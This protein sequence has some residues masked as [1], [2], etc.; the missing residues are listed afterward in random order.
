MRSNLPVPTI[1]GG[2]VAAASFVAFMSS[3]VSENF[4]E[5]GYQIV[6]FSIAIGPTAMISSMLGF[7]VWWLAKFL[8]ALFSPVDPTKSERDN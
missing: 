4:S 6:W 5:N 8:T 3:L 7:S 2:L 1:L